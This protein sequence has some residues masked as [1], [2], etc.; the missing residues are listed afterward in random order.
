ME[1][2]DLLPENDQ[3]L[4]LAKQLDSAL[5][6]GEGFSSIQD[7]LI[8]SLLAYQNKE[9]DQIDALSSESSE[10]WDKVFSET[11]PQ[12]KARITSLSTRKTNT[13]TWAT[14]ATVLLAAFL[15]IFW[16]TNLDNPVL[17]AQSGNAIESVI[18]ADGS[19]VSLRPNSSLYEIE[20]SDSKRSYELEGEAFF[21]VAKD[22]NKP[23][24]VTSDNG[25]VTVLGTQ[26]NLSTWGNETKVF[27][28]EGS[29]RLEDLHQN[30]V[31]LK[32]GEKATISQNLL[33]NASPADAE[34]F[35]DWLNNE[36]VLKSTP[37]SQVINELEHHFQVTIDISGMQNT[38][39]P[40]SGTIA[41]DELS[42]TLND[43]GIILGGTFREVNSNRF[44][45]I[46]LN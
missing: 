44:T 35:K 26:F 5:Q 28:E 43:L 4:L 20:L 13:W 7:P 15:G 40:I 30:S 12:K 8:Q 19:Q 34:E 2:K 22:A 39:E 9:H 31:I 38:S 11:K 17:V 18:L 36:I 25:I 41:L 45:F 24:S 27:L 10:I 37:V 1:T 33:S 3:D 23:F 42:T 46:P 32:P 6:S 29:V 21:V 16:F 14:A